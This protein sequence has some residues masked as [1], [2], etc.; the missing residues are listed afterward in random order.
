MIKNHLNWFYSG[1]FFDIES[2][3][4]R[5]GRSGLDKMLKKTAKGKI[6]YIISDML[7]NEKYKGDTM[8]QKTFTE[9]FMTSKKAKIL[10]RETDIM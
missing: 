2:G 1:V 7:M 4:H 3:L 9:D 8:L 6:D 10:G 5:R